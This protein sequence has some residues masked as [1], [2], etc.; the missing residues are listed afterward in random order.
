MGKGK[1]SSRDERRAQALRLP[2]PADAIVR[3]PVEDFN[4]LA[5]RYRLSEQQLALARDI[6]RRGKNK[7]AA[8]SC[9]RRKLEAIARL[10]SELRALRGE[11]ARLAAQREQVTGQLGQARARLRELRRRLLSS[12]RDPRGLPYPEGAFEL[13]QGDDGGVYLVPRAGEGGGG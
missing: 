11:R 2:L 7:A 4:E 12:L 5:S 13:R 6:R 9:R 1:G 3:L 8:Q 10:E